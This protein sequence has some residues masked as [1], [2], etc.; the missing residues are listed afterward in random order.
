MDSGGQKLKKTNGAMDSCGRMSRAE[1]YAKV[2][3]KNKNRGTIFCPCGARQQ[4]FTDD[5]EKKAKTS[6]QGTTES[7]NQLEN[8]PRKLRGLPCG[9]SSEHVLYGKAK[10]HHTQA[11][12]S[13]EI[14]TSHN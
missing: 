4:N 13:E 6:L 14:L 11:E 12:Y 7:I 8:R 3:V 2:A 5:Q 10:A 9:S 1:C